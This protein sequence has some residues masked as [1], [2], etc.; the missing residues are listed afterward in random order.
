M[1]CVNVRKYDEVKR[2]EME[3]TIHYQEALLAANNIVAYDD[4]VPHPDF[5]AACEKFRRVC[6]SIKAFLGVDT[7]IGSYEEL[8]VYKDCEEAQTEEGKRLRNDL[9]FYNQ[10]CIHEG[11]KI[12]LPPPYWFKKC[13]GI[14]G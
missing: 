1:S 11:N 8:E 2:E 12:G 10:L 4:S 14:D 5:E 6:A 9:E 13:W 3:R 7:F